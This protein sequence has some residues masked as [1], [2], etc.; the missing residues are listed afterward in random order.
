MQPCHSK[1]HGISLTL[2]YLKAAQFFLS[3]QFTGATN[4]SMFFFSKQQ[5][6]NKYLKE[7]KK[8]QIFRWRNFL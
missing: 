5:L 3:R 6:D 8:S 1:V 2:S 4:P 7:V